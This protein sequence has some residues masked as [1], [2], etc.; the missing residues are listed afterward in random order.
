MSNFWGAYQ[1]LAAASEHY[2]Y[3]DIAAI[4]IVFWVWGNEAHAP[5]NALRFAAWRRIL[6][7]A[8]YARAPRV[9]GRKKC[10]RAAFWKVGKDTEIEKAVV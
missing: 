4:G 8:E 2:F 5:R 3:M 7:Q 1:A 10:G 9:G 6:P